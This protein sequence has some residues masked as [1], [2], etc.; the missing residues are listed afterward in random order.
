[1]GE[2]ERILENSL[3]EGRPVAADLLPLIYDEL[4]SLAARKLPKGKSEQ[5]LQ[6]TALVHEAWLKLSA[7]E[8]Q[9]WVD[10]GH[11]YRTAALAMR[12]I[13]VDRARQKAALKRGGGAEHVHIE[14]VDVADAPP[15]ERVLLVNE[16]LERLEREHPE[17]AQVVSLKFFGGL[18]NKEIAAVQGVTERTVDRHWAYA[19]ARIFELIREEHGGD[20]VI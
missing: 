20:E 19:K 15:E 9:D 10:K 16:V 6:A 12:N 11:F 5:T 17:R 2:I 8:T 13:L 14:D 18:T 4:R 3:A 7:D 1:M